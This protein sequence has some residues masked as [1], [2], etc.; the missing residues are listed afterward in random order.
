MDRSK[1]CR[2][3]SSQTLSVDKTVNVRFDDFGQTDRRLIELED[4]FAYLHIKLADI[5]NHKCKI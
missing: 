5:T 1:A 4:D 2:V 3:F